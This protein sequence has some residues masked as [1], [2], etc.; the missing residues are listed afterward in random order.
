[1][2]SKLRR[3]QKQ[4]DRDAKRKLKQHQPIVKPFTAFEKKKGK[5][6][7]IFLVAMLVVVGVFLISRMN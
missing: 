3:L 4:K 2:S 7:V 1:M 5:Q 6:A